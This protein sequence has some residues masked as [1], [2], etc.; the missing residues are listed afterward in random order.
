MPDIA[1][2]PILDAVFGQPPADLVS[3]PPGA[4]QLSPLIP[5]DG[6]AA[7]EALAPGGLAS[8]VM[9]APPGT[10]ERRYAVALA[11]RSLAPG[12]AMT[13]LA[14]KSKGGSRLRAELEA[15]GCAIV[16]SSRQHHRICATTRPQ[17]PAGLAEAIAAGA[18]RFDEALGL[19]T[20]PGI[21]SWDR[22]DPGSALL[23][24][25]LAGLSGRGADLGCGTGLLARRVLAGPKVTA[26]ALVDID[27]RAV[28]G[29]RRNVEDARASFLWADLRQPGTQLGELDFVVM[30]PP[31]HAAGGHE[32]RGLGQSFIRAAAA[33]LRRGGLCRLV[34]NRHLPYEAVL[35]ELFSHVST[36]AEA[37]GYKVFEAR[38]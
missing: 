22:V 8:L 9:L 24:G 1:T 4:V 32:D 12:A 27:R 37:G 6:A 26:L 18:P 3:V 28:D 11:L 38:K 10:I 14:P 17:E 36:L 16:E 19:W 25:H 5:G 21:F 29:A 34:A 35:A 30:N 7:L 33:A 2:T 13:V 20:Q 23:A 15:F 31:F